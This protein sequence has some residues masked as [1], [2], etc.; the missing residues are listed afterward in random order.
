MYHRNQAT[1]VVACATCI[2]KHRC[3]ERH[4][5]AVV[6]KVVVSCFTVLVYVKVRRNRTEFCIPCEGR[7]RSGFEYDVV[8][9]AVSAEFNT[10]VLLNVGCIHEVYVEVVAICDIFNKQINSSAFIFGG[11]EVVAV[12]ATREVAILRVR[13]LV[14]VK[15]ISR[16]FGGLFSDSNRQI[17]TALQYLTGEGDLNGLTLAVANRPRQNI[18]EIFGQVS[19]YLHGI[20]VTVAFYDGYVGGSIAC[21]V[22]NRPSD[23]ERFVS[24]PGIPLVCNGVVLAGFYVLLDHAAVENFFDGFQSVQ[25]AVF[26]R[27][28]VIRRAGARR[29]C[30]GRGSS[31]GGRVSGFFAA[32]NH[33]TESHQQGKNA[34]EKFFHGGFSPLYN[35][36]IRFSFIAPQNAAKF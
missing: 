6:T 19:V 25:G 12:H 2:G 20:I 18:R 5:R 14:N 35:F 26:V 8:V 22:G 24:V 7:R 11:F 17:L 23:I 36:L 3:A 21:C 4:V 16:L 29:R 34:R 28:V 27:S 30:R 13:A 9:C 15:L 33:H 1:Y 32:T 31:R 10:D